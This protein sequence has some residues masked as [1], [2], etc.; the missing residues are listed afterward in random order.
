LLA[1][2]LTAPGDLLAS[3]DADP[4]DNIDSIET[5][6]R[7][8]HAAMVCDRGAILTPFSRAAQRTRITEFFDP[9]ESRSFLIMRTSA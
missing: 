3:I 5:M 1:G 6:I 9:S 2:I 4:Q 8:H 7:S